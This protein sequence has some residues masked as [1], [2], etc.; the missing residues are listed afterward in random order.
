ME[1][2]EEI[3]ENENGILDFEKACE[4]LDNNLGEY[5][6]KSE[7]LVSIIQESIGKDIERIIK[8][9]EKIVASILERRFG[10]DTTDL[11]ATKELIKRKKL[12]VLYDRD[13][14]VIGVV[15]NNRW[16]Y[17][18]R[19]QVIGKEGRRYRIENIR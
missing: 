3:F 18:P 8:E 11:E 6:A 7:E 1:T 10:V 16:L 19:G 12:G 17:T 9:K 15:Q 2:G 14:N 4:Y 13:Y 5:L